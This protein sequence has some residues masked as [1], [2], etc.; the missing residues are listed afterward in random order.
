MV[1]FNKLTNLHNEWIIDM[2]FG[3][4]DETLQAHRGSYKTTCVSIALT[5]IMIT[6][7]NDKTA[8]LRKTDTDIKEVI[9]QCKKIFEHPVT[10]YFVQ[11]IWGVDLK[12]TKATANEISTNLTNDP[13]G[14][15][16]LVGM[17]LGGSL[18]GKHFDRIFTDDIVNI[19][20]RISRAERE[21]TKLVYQELQNIIN[22]GGRIFNTGTPW[23]KEDCFELMPNPIK[24]DCYST[25][26]IS[27]EE[28]DE[29]RDSMLGSLFAANYELKHIAAEDVI[30]FNPAIGADRNLV[31]NA[32]QSHIDAAYTD[33]GDYTA[34][35]ICRK[36]SGKYYVYGRLWHKAV[37]SVESEII[38]E[39]RAF[40][41][42]KILMERNADKGLL[43]KEIRSRYN[44]PVETYHEDENKF[45]KIV[46]YLKWAWK[47]VVFVEGTDEEYIQ[48]ILDYNEYAEHDDAPDSLS[49]I[50]RKLWNRQS[51]DTQRKLSWAK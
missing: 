20:D 5:I 43:A 7:V 48:Q 46:T 42:N 28:L 14:T 24:Y 9:S 1:G 2:V 50:I 41:C 45:Q 13:R 17:G 23:H 27:D 10:R 19:Q 8:F 30:F 32:N 18:T 33:G 38:A 16:Q 35:T 26:L 39:H 36:L 44:I 29:L 47:N 3:D 49:S 37:D 21:R 4:D 12:L 51:D 15:A 25:G 22:R 11:A 34:F 31:L 6:A 40:L